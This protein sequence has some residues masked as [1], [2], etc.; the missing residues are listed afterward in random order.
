MNKQKLKKL[1]DYAV[2]EGTQYSED[3]RWSVS[4][5]ELFYHFGVDVND[6]NQNGKELAE[7]LRKREEISELIMTEDAIE[8]TYHMEYCESCQNDPASVL[9]V[10]GCNIYDEHTESNS[11]KPSDTVINAPLV[12]KQEEAYTRPCAI[13]KVVELSAKAFDVFLKNLLDDYEFLDEFNREGYTYENEITPCI[14]VLG[15]GSD[16]G[17]CVDTSGCS[18]ARFS[19]YI[20]HA[21]QIV[22]PIMTEQNIETEEPGPV[23]SM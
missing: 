4:Y 2:F 3:G 15:K 18:Y 13:K 11:E 5:D 17:V 6:T 20:P 1:A 8:M 16:D 7:E 12:R 9:S 14:M 22:E 21:R 19:A 10:L 23:Q